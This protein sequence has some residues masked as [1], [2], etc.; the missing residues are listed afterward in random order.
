M[1]LSS[2]TWAKVPLLLLSIRLCHSLLPLFFPFYKGNTQVKICLLV[3]GK[4]L[5]SNTPPQKKD[6]R[7]VGF[8][9]GALGGKRH[10]LD[11]E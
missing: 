4:R 9:L 5:N 1:R 3:F 11:A 6:Q 2:C 10:N 7:K 8:A